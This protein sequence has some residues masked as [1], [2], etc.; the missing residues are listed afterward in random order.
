M[1]IKGAST[2]NG[3]STH[4]GGMIIG[5]GYTIGGTGAGVQSP[6]LAAQCVLFQDGTLTLVHH[7]FTCI[8]LLPFV[9]R[10]NVQ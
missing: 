5:D 7:G 8:I 9:L 10:N 1:F 6:Q 4:V 3:E 2:L